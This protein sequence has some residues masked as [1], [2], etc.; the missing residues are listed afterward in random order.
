[1]QIFIQAGRS[2]DPGI[3]QLIPTIP[4]LTETSLRMRSTYSICIC[5]QGLVLVTPGFCTAYPDLRLRWAGVCVFLCLG[6][7][8]AKVADV[9]IFQISPLIAG[10]PWVLAFALNRKSLGLIV[11]AV[12][13]AFCCS[14]CSLVRSGATLI[15]LVFLI[16]LFTGRCRVQQMVLSCLLVVLACVPSMIFERYLITRRDA[17]LARFGEDATAVNSHPLW[18]S[19]YIGLGFI[20]NSEVPEY[21]DAVAIDKVRSIDPTA[22][23]TSV[24]YELILRRE[25][26][27]LARHRPLLL[28]EN[29]AAKTG[30]VALLAL[31]LLFPARR[32]L[33]AEKDALWLDAAFVLA[34][35]L[36]AMSAILVIP[37]PPYLLTF[38]C[39]TLLYSSMKLCRAFSIDIER[40]PAIQEEPA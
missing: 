12:L 16:T 6:L 9:Y 22:P 3:A 26:L 25:M 39:L 21:N 24:K 14:W 7:A 17:T 35:G 29:L 13:L 28:I 10:I 34:I 2:D 20:P 1:M 31:I 40:T 37:R 32:V 27:N 33:F 23:Y 15:C 5:P 36:S 19:M 8:E 18:H 30:F 11:S 4:H 38:L